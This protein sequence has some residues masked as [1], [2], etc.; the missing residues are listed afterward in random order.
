MGLNLHIAVDGTPDEELSSPRLVEVEQRAGRMTAYRIHYAVDAKDGDYPLLADPRL[1][2]GSELSVLVPTDAGMECLVKGPVHKQEICLRGGSEGS[3]LVVHGADTSLALD[4][5]SKT[6]IWSDQTD[7]DAVS[8]ILG[9]AGFMGADVEAT[10]AS[11]ALDKHA[12]VQ[13]DTDYRFIRKLARRNGYLFWMSYDGDGMDTA[14]FAPPSLEGEPAAELV[15]NLKLPE[16]GSLPNID[17]LEIEW[18]VEKATSVEAA[19][20]DLNT[21]GDIDGS[22]AKSEA[23]LLGAKGLQDITG[24]VRSHRVTAAV[25]DAGDLKARGQAVLTEASWFLKAVCHTS[26]EQVRQA[27]APPALVNV[28]GAGS[29]H[30]G[31]YLIRAVHHKINAVAH[32]M[33]IELVRNAWEA[34]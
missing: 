3:T 13:R 10:D 18:D 6:A 15:L 21:K 9:D 17:R 33:D 8:A 5:E 22:A 27:L 16:H 31:L 32:K 11:H 2:P 7:S 20:L 19:Q 12:L 24:D 26:M 28:R 4:R 30:S 29:R 34:G 23:T 25:D 14:H 1:D